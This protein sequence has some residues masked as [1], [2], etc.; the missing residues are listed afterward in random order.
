ML[1]RQGMVVLDDGPQS[2]AENMGIDLSGRDVGVPKHLLHASK[3][4]SVIQ[5]MGRERVAQDMR[6]DLGRID[7]TFQGEFLEQL[8][9]PSSG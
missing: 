5:K 3:V 8:S 6:R 7:P 9:E 2:L 1:F 4:R